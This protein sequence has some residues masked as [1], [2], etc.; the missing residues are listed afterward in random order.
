MIFTVQH[1]R[2]EHKGIFY[3]EDNG[4][5]IAEMT[6]SMAGDDKMIIDH[7]EVDQAYGGQGLGEKLV[8]AGVYYAREHNIKILPLCP[9][10]KAQIQRHTEWQ[11]I[12][13]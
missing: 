1:Q 5:R 6:Y 3:L 11:D 2:H 10:A 8:E 13:P 7:T 12:L 9:F 4:A